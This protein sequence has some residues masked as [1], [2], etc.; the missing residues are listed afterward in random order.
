M[1]KRAVIVGAGI[2]GL[3][4]A[5]RLRRAGWEPVVVEAADGRVGLLR[6]PQ[7]GRARPVEPRPGGSAGRRRLV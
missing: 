3:G 6:H 1:S 2:A 5:L 7:P 4:A